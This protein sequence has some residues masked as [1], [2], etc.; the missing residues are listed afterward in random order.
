MQFEE[1][2]ALQGPGS[3]SR[4][5]SASGVVA[6]RA[7]SS[8]SKANAAA[9]VQQGHATVAVTPG[10]MHQVTARAPLTQALA[11]AALGCDRAFQARLR[12]GSRRL[13]TLHG[14]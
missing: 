6:R 13:D 9:G 1:R 8:A 14:R 7:G 4:L 12:A 2:G 3:N 10:Q 11:Q 5:K